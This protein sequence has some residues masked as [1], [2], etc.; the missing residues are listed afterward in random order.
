[1]WLG[2]VYPA[3]TVGRAAPLASVSDGTAS[4]CHSFGMRWV[5]L[6]DGRWSNALLE[7]DTLCHGGKSPCMFLLGP[8]HDEL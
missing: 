1:M 4:W 2:V 7:L 8:C 6:L 5:V 3:V